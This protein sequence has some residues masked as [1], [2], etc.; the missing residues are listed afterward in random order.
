MIDPRGLTFQEWADFSVPDFERF[1]LVG[2]ADDP[3]DWR[4]WCN[5]VANLSELQQRGVPSPYEFG[6][7][8]EWAM[9]VAQQ[10]DKG[11]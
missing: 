5:R 9:A 11:L 10:F 3:D 8:Q 2:R 7:W 1:G 4:S 6:D